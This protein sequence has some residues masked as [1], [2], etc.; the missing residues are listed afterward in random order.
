MIDINYTLYCPVFFKYPFSCL[1]CIEYIERPTNALWFYG[2]SCIGL[3][4]PTCFGHTCGDLQAGENK[5]TNV[6]KMCQN[7]STGT[8]FP[9]S[10]VCI[11]HHP[12]TNLYHISQCILHHPFTN[13]YHISQCIL[14][15]PF[16]NLY[17]ISPHVSFTHIIPLNL[18]PP[19]KKQ[20][21]TSNILYSLLF[22]YWAL[23][24]N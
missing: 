21:L 15:H 10:S 2:F 5:N 20:F 12:F 17:H 18:T 24:A 23:N 9:S 6:I 14:H 8:K 4:S 22:Y 7:P 11:L 16:T 19:Q 13:L 1:K 3:L